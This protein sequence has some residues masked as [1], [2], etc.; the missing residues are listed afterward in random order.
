MQHTDN[1]ENI[2]KEA[3]SNEVEPIQD[4]VEQVEQPSEQEKPNH[5]D[6]D[7]TILDAMWV[8]GKRSVSTMD[9]V[10]S[11]FDTNR[12]DSYGQNYAYEIRVGK[13]RL[14]RMLA[15]SPYTLEKI[16]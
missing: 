8:I 4:N 14:S 13:Y 12:I 3:Q 1:T 15:F 11:G 9:L 6:P 2:E 7:E 10:S 5:F 16:E